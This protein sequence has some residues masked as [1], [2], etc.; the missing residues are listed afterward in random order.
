MGTARFFDYILYGLAAMIQIV[1]IFNFISH[2]GE[3]HKRVHTATHKCMAVIGLIVSIVSLGLIL[4]NMW[5]LAYYT[6]VG[7]TLIEVYN[8]L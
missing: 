7:D 4:V 8:L 6:K 3:K 5:L 2:K 1:K